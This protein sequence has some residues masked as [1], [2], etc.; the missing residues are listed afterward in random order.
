M[1]K[2]LIAN[3]GEI[4]RRIIRTA[5]KMGIKTVAVFSEADRNALFVREAYEAVCIGQASSKE[6]YLNIE[7]IIA[8]AKQTQADAVHPG[9]GF[10]SE[11][12]AFSQAVQDAGLIFVGPSP[13]SIRLMGDKISSK[14][15]ARTMNVPLLPGTE[16]SVSDPALAKTKA[17]EIG[18]PVI[19]K[20]SAGGGGKG[21]R[22][23][24]HVDQL[25]EQIGLASRE[26][27]SSF[28][29]GSVFI[30]KYLPAPKH[31][32]IQIIADK[33]GNTFYFHEREC[34]IQRRYQKVIEE[35]PSPS[36]NAQ[37][38]K[39][40][41]EAAV[42][43]A[44]SCNYSGAGTVEFL[45]D[46]SMNFY[47]MEMNT[48]LQVEHP[49]TEMIT[50]YD[51]VELQIKI[52]RNE[53]LSFKQSEIPM[54]GHAIEA[55]INAED[56]YSE[57]LPSIGVLTEYEIPQGVG[58]RVDDAYMKGQE[59]PIHYDSMI[60]KLIVHA[61]D[62]RMAIE[63]MKDALH[64]YRIEGVNTII[65][66]TQFILNHEEFIQGTMTT[67]FVEHTFQEFLNSSMDFEESEAASLVAFYHFLREYKK[68]KVPTRK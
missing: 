30:E 16:N 56:P 29:D 34:S 31:I 22:I 12:E 62:R 55:R 1:K 52:A 17:I 5:H 53:V 68:V 43:I 66:Y 6:S 18:L 19:I 10:L 35:A 64:D 54:N 47:F 8:A 25:E 4:A 24:Y 44:Q 46:E 15:C 2:L 58:V 39:E 51:L 57:F 63:K 21:M 23:V 42:R 60:A 59:I 48:R 33:H 40:I 67:K 28:G 61:Q 13:N 65:P 32:E 14:Q 27:L 45:L 50:G 20:A 49:V 9:Y 3:R 7:K 38:R 36:L 11:R 37:L 41:G 26:A